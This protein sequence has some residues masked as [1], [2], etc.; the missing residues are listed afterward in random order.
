MPALC[1]VDVIDELAATT[2][3]LPLG[4]FCDRA[5]A[6]PITDGDACR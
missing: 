3:Q 2:Y 6:A 1:G 5:S 4:R